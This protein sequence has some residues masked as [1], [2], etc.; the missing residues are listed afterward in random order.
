MVFGVVVA[1]RGAVWSCQHT[2]R[3]EPQSRPLEIWS[4]VMPSC[5]DNY[6][7]FEK[8]ALGLLWGHSRD[9]MLNH[10]PQNYQVTWVSHHELAVNCDPPSHEVW[11]ALVCNRTFGHFSLKAKWI[12]RCA[13]HSSACQLGGFPFT[14]VPQGC[15]R[16]QLS[17]C[18]CHFPVVL[19]YHAESFVNQASFPPSTDCREL[20]MRP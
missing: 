2:S 20:S 13:A 11:Y 15:P 5:T 9:W 6:S 17:C 12:T 3:G 7:P 10:G 14:R 16:K 1:G 8:M 19:A 4:K 18:S